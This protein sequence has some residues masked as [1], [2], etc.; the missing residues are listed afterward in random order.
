MTKILK[1]FT[2]FFVITSAGA[3]SNDLFGQMRAGVKGGLNVRDKRVVVAGTGPLLLVVAE[4]LASKGAHV[5]S[6]VSL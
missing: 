4:Y 3:I 2:V 1:I 6:G 5:A